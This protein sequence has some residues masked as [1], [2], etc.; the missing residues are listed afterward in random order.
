MRS[1][2]IDLMALRSIVEEESAMD[3]MLSVGPSEPE[4][5]AA[6]LYSKGYLRTGVERGLNST[7]TYW[8]KMLPNRATVSVSTTVKTETK[9][10]EKIWVRVE[11][12]DYISTQPKWTA[13][14]LENLSAE[15]D[16]VESHALE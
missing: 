10:V 5:V 6:I 15:L 13:L 14:S 11:P 7:F 9:S 2:M 4:R 16:K 8:L 3:F 1:I 12:S